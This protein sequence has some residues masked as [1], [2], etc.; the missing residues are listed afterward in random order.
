MHASIGVF[1]LDRYED[2]CYFVRSIDPEKPASN[3]RNLNFSLLLRSMQLNHKVGK[4]RNR[5]LLLQ[6][7]CRIGP[8]SNTMQP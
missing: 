5:T 2:M 4:D 8:N 7:Y 3:Q 6:A 1:L